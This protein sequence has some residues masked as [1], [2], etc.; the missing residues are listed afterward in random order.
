MAPVEM[1]HRLQFGG[2]LFDTEQWSCSISFNAQDSAVAV[3]AGMVTALEDWFGRSQS[4]ISNRATLEFV[5]YN[6][7]NPVTGKYVLPTSN[8]VVVPTPP[9]GQAASFAP[10]LSVS[11]GLTT[12]LSRG[13]GH[14]GRFYPPSGGSGA[15]I[16][17][18]GR[19]SE[20]FVQD[21]AGSAKTLILALNVAA[22]TGEAVIFSKVDQSVTV[23]N[24]VRVGRVIDTIRSRRS[25][26]PEQYHAIG[27]LP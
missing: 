1:L 2:K 3:P 22:G 19:V 27:L 15:N 21:T 23:V 9:T 10:Q 25:S 5:K 6:Q 7:I 17:A 8:T 18:D 20:A 11:V 13:R 16:G 4:Q 24:G 12:V 26:L 14:A